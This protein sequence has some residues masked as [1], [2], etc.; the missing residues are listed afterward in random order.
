M[1]KGQII[2]NTAD[3]GNNLELMSVQQKCFDIMHLRVMSASRLLL[4][5][6]SVEKFRKICR[7]WWGNRLEINKG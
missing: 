2:E 4:R 6:R 5:R 7:S 1:K 3:F